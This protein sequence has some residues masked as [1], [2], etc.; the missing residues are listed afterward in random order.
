MQVTDE[1][2]SLPDPAPQ[3]GTRAAGAGARNLL[4]PRAPACSS[5]RSHVALWQLQGVQKARAALQPRPQAMRYRGKMFG[6]PEPGGSQRSARGGCRALGR[7]C[8]RQRS[9]PAP[10]PAARGGQRLQAFL[11]QWDTAGQA[12]QEDNKNLKNIPY[13]S[14]Q[15]RASD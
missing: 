13:T 1:W 11:R 8:A 6:G 7:G 10:L 12:G 9:P 15:L 2:L 5:R 3:T 14:W 4:L